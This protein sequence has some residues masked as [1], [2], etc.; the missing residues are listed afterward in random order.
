VTV[1]RISERL[2]IDDDRI[3]FVAAASLT[4]GAHATVLERNSDD[5]SVRTESG[6]HRIPAAI[7]EQLHVTIG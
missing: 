2:E 7:A 1:A 3:R 4:P 5:I 6:E